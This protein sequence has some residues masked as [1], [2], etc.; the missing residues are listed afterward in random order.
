MRGETYNQAELKIHD[1]CI[2]HSP[3][4]TNSCIHVQ[5]CMDCKVECKVRKVRFCNSWRPRF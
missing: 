5:L 3:G 1:N 4:L 2:A